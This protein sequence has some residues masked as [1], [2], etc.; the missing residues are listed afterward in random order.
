V[1]QATGL[2]E[3]LDDL[4]KHPSEDRETVRKEFLE[5][6]TP[7]QIKASQQALEACR[8]E[9]AKLHHGDAENLN[10]WQTFMPWCREEI[11]RIYRR[12]D[13]HF[14]YTHGESFYNPMLPA[15]V[16]SLVEHG[17]AE[18]S[19]GALVI[20]FGDKEIGRAHV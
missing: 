13:V 14:D 6:Y 10:L 9:T 20:F 16:Q 18:E 8:R 11:D 7:E 3:E 15:V 17:L 2:A 19:R 5:K 1:K 4:E 12:L